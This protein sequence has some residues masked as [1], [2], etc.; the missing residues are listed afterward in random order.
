MSKVRVEAFTISADGYGAGPDQSLENP[1]GVGGLEIHK[2]FRPTNTFQQMVMGKSGETG[3]DDDFAKRGFAGV[4][5]HIMGRN[6]FGP[7]RGE[8]PDDSW[9][10]WWGNNPPYH[11]PVF[12]LTNHPRESIVMEGGTTFHFI[13]GGIHEAMDRAQEAAGDLD[14][15]ISGGVSTVRQYLE[16]GMVDEMHLVISPVLLGAGENLFF[17]LDLAKLGYQ[18]VESVSTKLATHLIVSRISSQS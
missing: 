6:M 15:R 10:G 5:A 16:A 1:L 2:W 7:V 12:V 13:T 3:V 11:T 18:V 9:Q 14:I 17:G 8:W 4:G